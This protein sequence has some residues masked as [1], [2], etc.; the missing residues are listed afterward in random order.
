[1]YILKYNSLNPK[2]QVPT[3]KQKN[4]PANRSEATWINFSPSSRPDV[5]EKSIS[6]MDGFRC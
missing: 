1:M 6:V 3:K 5:A 2:D 4:H